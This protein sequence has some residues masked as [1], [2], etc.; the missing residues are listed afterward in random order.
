MYILANI[1]LDAA[2]NELRKGS[3]KGP[4]SSSLLVKSPVA[5][6]RPAPEV[7][8]ADADGHV[9][10]PDAGSLDELLLLLL[11]Q[12]LLLILLLIANCY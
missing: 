3:K 2:E 7:Q 10:R 8:R 9:S 11:Q 1:G 12:L 6:L 5:V 4:I